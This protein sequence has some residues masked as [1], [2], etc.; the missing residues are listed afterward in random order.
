[1]AKV[2]IDNWYDWIYRIWTNRLHK[3]VFNYNITFTNSRFL[4]QSSDNLFASSFNW[5][6]FSLK[7]SFTNSS[8]S[9]FV[10][11]SSL[12]LSSL[13][14]TYAFN[15][16]YISNYKSSEQNK[17]SIDIFAFLRQVCCVNKNLQKLSRTFLPYNILVVSFCLLKW[18]KLLFDF[19]T[20]LA[21]L[22][23]TIWRKLYWSVHERWRIFDWSIWR[24]SVK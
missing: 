7:H 10:S 6:D 13:L 3:Q 20:V 5:L 23:V 9:S 15:H 11:L 1:M 18:N 24:E 14:K 2:F 8:M 16:S 4:I 12:L 22:S 17:D 19:Y 21:N